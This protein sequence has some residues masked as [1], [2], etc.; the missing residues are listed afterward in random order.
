MG[1]AYGCGE[2][3]VDLAGC[4][5]CPVTVQGDIANYT[6]VPDDSAVVFVSCV[7]EYVNDV[8]AA[9]REIL[10]MAG[11]LE[12]VFVVCVQPHT[13]TS[14]LYPGARRVVKPNGSYAPVTPMR[15]AAYATAVGALATLCVV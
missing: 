7:L 2:V 14:V 12:N 13:M 5:G 11:S 3:C 6:G 8:D 10:R 15:K 9:W 1:P 4:T